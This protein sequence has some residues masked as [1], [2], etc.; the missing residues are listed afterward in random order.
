[1]RPRIIAAAVVLAAVVAIGG[2]YKPYSKS[3]SVRAGTS[4]DAAV[5]LGTLRARL[6]KVKQVLVMIKVTG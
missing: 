5:M 3:L 1:M 4:M 6:E 2:R